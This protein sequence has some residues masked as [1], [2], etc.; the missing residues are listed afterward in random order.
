MRPSAMS[1]RCNLPA[2]LAARHAGTSIADLV[3]GVH[4]PLL[5]LGVVF[6]SIV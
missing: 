1:S 4:R 5:A 6:E 2:V 3:I